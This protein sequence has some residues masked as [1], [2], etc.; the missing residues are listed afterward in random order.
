MIRWVENTGVHQIQ[1]D[2]RP[3][4]S[5]ML[6]EYLLILEKVDEV[7]MTRWLTRRINDK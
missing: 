2:K 4:I 7:D 6:S 1:F 5:K 3:V